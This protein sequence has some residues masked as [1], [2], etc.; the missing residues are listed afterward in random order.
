[1]ITEEGH[2]IWVMLRQEHIKDHMVLSLEDFLKNQHPMDINTM[3]MKIT[4]FCTIGIFL[5][6]KDY[7]LSWE[8]EKNI[9]LNTKKTKHFHIF[10]LFNDN[11]LTYFINFITF[12]SFSNQ[13]ELPSSFFFWM[14]WTSTYSYCISI[15]WSHILHLQMPLIIS[16]IFPV[17]L[18]YVNQIMFLLHNSLRIQ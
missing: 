18:E 4:W 14:H 6:C 12:I 7:P 2:Y 8:I 3:I 10:F 13:L 15:L 9:H 1:M 5:T 16:L 17:M 11:E